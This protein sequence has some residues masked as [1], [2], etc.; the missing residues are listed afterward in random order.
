MDFR[1]R[2]ARLMRA[3]ESFDNFHRII[4]L[5]A[6]GLFLVS[7]IAIANKFMPGKLVDL[8]YF[9]M[10]WRRIGFCVSLFLVLFLTQLFSQRV[11]EKVLSAFEREATIKAARR[12]Y[13]RRR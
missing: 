7:S 3:K 6:L 5:I 8:V 2:Y 10:S 12:D 1:D 13:L 11:G 4:D 9:D